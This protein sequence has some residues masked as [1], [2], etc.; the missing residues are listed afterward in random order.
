MEA[1]TIGSSSPYDCC[2][3]TRKGASANGYLVDLVE[4]PQQGGLHQCRILLWLILLL[5]HRLLQLLRL[6]LDLVLLHAFGSSRHFV[7]AKLAT[8]SLN[9]KLRVLST[10]LVPFRVEIPSRATGPK[11]KHRG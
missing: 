6:L 3:G 8:E 7:T 5:R 2:R 1:S 11:K 9:I 10:N 4:A